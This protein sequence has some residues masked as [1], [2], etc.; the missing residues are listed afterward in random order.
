MFDSARNGK[1]DLYTRPANGAQQEQLLYHDD[2]DK[3][4]SAWSSDGKYVAYETVNNGHIDIWMM[5]MSGDHKPFSYL[6]E[7]YNTRYPIFSPDN[8]WISYTSL[9]SGH[10]QIY[11][12]A[13]PT[14][15]GKFLV[16]DGFGSQWT[17]NGKEIFY[18]DDQNRIVSVEVTA[19]G[20]SLEL[21]RP[22]ILFTTQSA[23]PG[24]FEASP[25]GKR[26][27][28]M[29]APVQN[30]QD[31]TLVVNWPAELKK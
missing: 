11:A 31:L 25:D 19:H 22:Q 4:P 29:Q 24:L 13:F 17:R 7:K 18:V 8:K 16:G 28:M 2:A 1:I 15:G 26:F 21:G 12:V 3:Y 9:E 30:S 14:P 10:P 23:G 27:L 6:R 5:P 20:D